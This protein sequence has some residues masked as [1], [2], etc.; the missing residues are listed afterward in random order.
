[1]MDRV[2][3]QDALCTAGINGLVVSPIAVGYT[4]EGAWKGVER[5][6]K[7][8]KIPNMQCRDDM[9]ERTLKRLK[10]ITEMGW[11]Q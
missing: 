4:P 2:Q 5:L 6:T 10:S 7:D 8:L 11:L 3:E 9:E 1:M